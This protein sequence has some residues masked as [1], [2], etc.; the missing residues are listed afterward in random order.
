MRLSGNKD[1]ENISVT[2]IDHP[3]NPGYPTY[4]HARTYGLFAANP[5]GEAVFTKGEKQL[6]FSL[7]KGESVTFK[8]KIA[9]K[10]GSEATAGELDKLFDGFSE[11]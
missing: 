9:I 1:G 6:N 10:S 8:Y 4:W 11:K 7:D 3:K 2:I 5:L